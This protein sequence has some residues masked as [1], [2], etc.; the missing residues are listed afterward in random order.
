M[1]KLN[2]ILREEALAD[3]NQI[4]DESDSRAG[5]LIQEA[6]KTASMRLAVHRRRIESEIRAAKNRAQ[7]AA[8]LAIAT[9]RIQ[10]KGKIIAVVR[11]KALGAIEELAGTSGYRKILLALA[12]EAIQAVDAPEAVVVNL[13]DKGIISDWALQKRIEV[14]TDAELRFGVRL[15]SHSSK[16]S[17][18]NSLL[19]RLDRSWDMLSG[20]VA[21][22]LWK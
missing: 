12:D 21:Q 6:E 7:G 8:E 13:N 10:A 18:E 2:D 20:R 5:N 9:A 11:K 16:H 14:R 19:E 17:V 15:V 22:I 4:R 3:I 1:S